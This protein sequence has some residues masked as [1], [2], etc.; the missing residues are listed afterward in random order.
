MLSGSVFLIV[1]D[2]EIL[3]QAATN[4]CHRE[5]FRPVTVPVTESALDCAA[6]CRPDVVL[7]DLSAAGN[8]IVSTALLE[9][10]RQ[11]P[12]TDAAILFWIS[13]SVDQSIWSQLWTCGAD[14][15]LGPAAWD[16]TLFLRVSLACQQRQQQRAAVAEQA[17]LRCLV[18]TTS[19]LA[20]SQA[21]EEALQIL[22][23]GVH[24]VAGAPGGGVRLL[25]GPAAT[26]ADQRYRVYRWSGEQRY[27]WEEG[28][29][30]AGSYMEQVLLT[31]AGV[32]TPDH[33][34]AAAQGHPFAALA[35]AQHGVQSSLIVPLRFP[36]RLLGT[37]HANA[38]SPHAFRVEQLEPLQV[39]ADHAA[40]AIERVQLT[41]AREAARSELQ[42]ILDTTNEAILLLAPDG[43]IRSLNRRA[44]ELFQLSAQE[45]RGRLLT[46]LTPHLARS[47]SAPTL[48]EDMLVA[49]PDGAPAVPHELVQIEP[50]QRIFAVETTAV[51]AQE[52]SHL[53]QLIVLRDVTEERLLGHMREEFISFISH[54]LRTPLTSIKG[55]VDLL[56]AGEMGP[57]PDEQRE[58]L[59][60]VEQ[61]IAR[62][63]A[64]IN[65]LLD[66]S[67]LEAGKLRL[68]RV[69]L[70]LRPLAEE[71]VQAFRPQ[72]VTKGHQL[73]LQIS[74]LLPTVFADAGRLRQIVTNLISNAHKY[75][76]GSGCIT[77]RVWSD[78]RAL[79]LSVSDTGIGMDEAERAQLFTKFFRANNQLTRKESGAGLGLVITR[80]LVELHGGKITVESVPGRGSTFTVSLPLVLPGAVGSDTGP[81]G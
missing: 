21:V 11:G 17:I 15:W 59:Q 70:Q 10:L 27:L 5:G 48:L 37:L 63:V 58:S 38:P 28:T 43:R 55:Y 9:Q 54:E 36:G 46:D 67:R 78:D 4:A 19:R 2:R 31:G 53:G 80:Q 75:T 81:R 79:L 20:A 23:R 6:A 68:E 8:G 57:L 45:A 51:R 72:L 24:E 7:L 25:Q 41:A 60:I 40:A 14:G 47:F 12:A 62:E 49:A 52:S 33:I 16:D 77:V 3:A 35:V 30:G 1:T 44:E 26:V 76:P 69:P 39:L 65:D 50:V 71:V 42:A 22:L 74:P 32:Y 29:V 64:L 61:N 18:E 66:V 73:T 56:I 13:P 34:T